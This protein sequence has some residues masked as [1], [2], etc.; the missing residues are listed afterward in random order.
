MEFSRIED[1]ISQAFMNLSITRVDNSGRISWKLSHDSPIDDLQAIHST[2]IVEFPAE[3]PLKPPV[4]FCSDSTQ[5]PFLGEGNIIPFRRLRDENTWK[6]WIPISVIIA[7]VNDLFTSYLSSDPLLN[8]CA[9]PKVLTKKPDYDMKIPKTAINKFEDIQPYVQWD[10]LDTSPAEIP[11][12]YKL[13]EYLKLYDDQDELAEIDSKPEKSYEVSR[14]RPAK[15]SRTA[16][17]GKRK[18]SRR[19]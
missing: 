3:Y 16:T 15:S 4:I 19:R 5:H 11:K 2:I 6:S 12:T 14:Q 1:F 9:L 13:R 17:R 18:S 7:G 8:G 10:Y